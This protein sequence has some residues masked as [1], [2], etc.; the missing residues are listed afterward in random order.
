MMI[1]EC[2]SNLEGSHLTYN[3]LGL[4]PEGEGERSKWER[5]F[6]TNTVHAHNITK[7]LDL[8]PFCLQGFPKCHH[9][10]IYIYPLGGTAKLIMEIQA[11]K[12]YQQLR[13]YWWTTESSVSLDFKSSKNNHWT[14]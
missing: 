9:T 13:L 3:F 1:K 8:V 12:V 5:L 14:F 2:I 7:A 10:T 11:D 6:A 4:S